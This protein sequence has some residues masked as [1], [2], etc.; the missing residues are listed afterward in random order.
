MSPRLKLTLM[1]GALSGCQCQGPGLSTAPRAPG[2]P[3]GVVALSDVR[4]QRS[5][6][7]RL[8][9]HLGAS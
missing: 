9:T 4:A 6:G 7:P 1:V 8:T 2:T 5:R 3:I